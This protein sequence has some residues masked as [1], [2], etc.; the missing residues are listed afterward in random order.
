[1]IKKIKLYWEMSESEIERLFETA[2]RE[3][4]LDQTA[5]DLRVDKN[6]FMIFAGRAEVFG[7][8]YDREVRP[9]GFFYLDSFEGSTARIHFCLFEAGRPVRHELGRLVLNWCFETFD[10]KCLRGVIPAINAGAV[11]YAR[12]MGGSFRGLIPGS[13]WIERL[14][15]TVAGAHFIFQRPACQT[16]AEEEVS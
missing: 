8:V 4:A 9:F 13:C 3:G 6:L 10:F 12:E 2:R 5:Y 15:R 1:M 11:N 16:G 7:T 14:R